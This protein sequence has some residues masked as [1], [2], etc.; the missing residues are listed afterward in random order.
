[1]A[2]K[3]CIVATYKDHDSRMPDKHDSKLDLSK[4]DDKAKKEALNQNNLAV[5]IYTLSFTSNQLVNMIYESCND[6]FPGGRAWEIAEALDK[7]YEPVDMMTIVERK[8]DLEKIKMTG[9]DHPSI[10]FEQLCGI[11]NKFKKSAAKLSDKEM[12]AYVI[13]KAPACYLQSITNARVQH[14]DKC[15]C[16]NLEEAMEIFWRT[17]QGMRANN[18]MK[19]SYDQLGLVAANFSGVC[20]R[21]GDKG[22]MAKDCDKADD[23]NKSTILKE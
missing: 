2:L 20:Y 14:G 6:D 16:D 17:S 1:M 10:L 7:K 18:E 3:N 9:K 11:K 13:E 19:P 21:C 22:H 5:A 15:T 12:Q 23:S 4:D 8:N